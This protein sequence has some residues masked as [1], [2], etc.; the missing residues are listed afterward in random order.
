MNSLSLC[1]V[2]HLSKSQV[3]VRDIVTFAM[4]L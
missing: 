4:V 3:I 2:R 1:G